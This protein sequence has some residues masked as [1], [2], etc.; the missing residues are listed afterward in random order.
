MQLRLRRRRIVRDGF[1][2]GN[3][4]SERDA[5]CAVAE[6]RRAGCR[7]VPRAS[8]RAECVCGS[9]A[10]GA[11]HGLIAVLSTALAPSGSLAA[12]ASEN[13]NVSI[14]PSASSA[15][16]QRGSVQTLAVRKHVWA[17]E[18]FGLHAAG[19]SPANPARSEAHPD[20]RYLA[21][22]TALARNAG[23][24][25]A[26][27]ERSRTS[28]ALSNTVGASAPF[29]VSNAGIGTSTDSYVS[30]PA[31]LRASSAHANV[32][33]DAT[34]SFDAP[35]LQQIGAHFKP[36]MPPIRAISERRNIQ[37]PRPVRA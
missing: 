7:R 1:A 31:T 26:P 24:S 8:E 14:G 9:I 13:V 36:P 37:R 32:W 29:W 20:E 12:P 33:I 18:I 35:S 21:T 4:R 30:V 23:R 15:M 34:L 16:L 19:Q 22:L 5:A 2:S 6:R 17:A 25:P 27:L 28:Q 3:R 10:A 11:Q